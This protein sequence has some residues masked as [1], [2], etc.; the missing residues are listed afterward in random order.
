MQGGTK[1]DECG[2]EKE[3]SERE[4]GETMNADL[5]RI[6]GVDTKAHANIGYRQWR[7]TPKY[8]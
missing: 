6:S 8:T 7:V 5:N 3:T 1:Q 4:G 2:K